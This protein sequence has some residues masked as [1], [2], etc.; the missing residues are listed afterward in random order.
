MNARMSRLDRRPQYAPARCAGLSL[1]ELLVAITI[2]MVLVAGALQVYLHSRNAY[3][4]SETAARLQE[5]ARYALSILEPD[6]RMAGYWGLLKNAGS[7]VTHSAGPNDA[8]A[9]IGGKAV[10]TCGNN[11]AVDLN[12]SIM[13]TNNSYPYA[14]PCDGYKDANTRQGGPLATADTLTIRRAS[15]VQ[16]ATGTKGPLRVCSTRLLAVLT[17]DPANDPV[18]TQA[19]TANAQMNALLVHLYYVDTASSAGLTVPSLRR[20]SYDPTAGDMVDEEVI[21]GVEDMQVQFGIDPTGGYGANGGAATQYLNADDAGAALAGTAQIVSVRVWLLV[22]ADTPEVGFV[23][24]HVYEYGERDRK[25]GYTADLTSTADATKAYKPSASA[26]TAFTDV[27][28]YRR[29]LICK[30]LYVRNV[31]GI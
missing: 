27:R 8:P 12:D 16:D 31:L 10:S 14:T 22:R 20:Y 30:T 18:C 2:S 7:A 23:D 5:N 4:T 26:N 29:L 11:F 15:D 19:T 24:D 3:T 9:A 28:H 21:T 13:G 6:V 17:N 1:V 25:N